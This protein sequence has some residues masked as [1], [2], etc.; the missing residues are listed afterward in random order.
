MDV[1]VIVPVYN[2][3][4]YL[5][6]CLDS[7]LS[8]TGVD[9]EVICIN[10]G[11]T[12]G[13]SEILKRAAEEDSRVRIITQEN[14]GQ[15]AARNR[16]LEVATGK[17]VYFL[18]SD[19][20][21]IEG[22]LARLFL[23]AEREDL[24]HVIFGAESFVDESHGAIDGKM[25]SDTESYYS[26]KNP[27]IYQVVC[28][29]PDLFARLV[30]ADSFY[31][32]PPLRFLRRDVI[33]GAHLRFVEGV[34]HEDN[35]FTPLALFASKRAV[36]IP[37]KLYRRRLRY[38]S[39]MTAA[40]AAAK[41]AAACFAVATRLKDGFGQKEGEC[42]ETAIGHYLGFLFELGWHYLSHSKS[43]NRIAALEEELEKISTIEQRRDI[44]YVVLPL[45]K[46]IDVANVRAQKY[47]DKRLSSRLKRL[48]KRIFSIEWRSV[49]LSMFSAY[50]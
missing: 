27:S 16:A 26:V 30:S 29:G 7:V 38:G 24:D 28:R 41:H 32:S 45:L 18:D 31:V 20:V 34:I 36:V 35:H 47:R 2:V 3:E 50:R 40:D 44:K 14:R 43:K 6:E 1:S 4:P 13:S 33:E 5:Q 17:Y 19:D 11:S 39:T 25:L 48:V 9:L 23:F 12:D 15:S 46:S 21:L 8:Q 37:D 10:D 49:L 22:M 42:V